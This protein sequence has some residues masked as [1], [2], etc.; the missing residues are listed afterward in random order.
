MMQRALISNICL[1]HPD[2]VIIGSIGTISYD[3]TSLNFPNKILIRGA[4]GAALGCGLGYAM[5][6]DKEVVV[7]IGD[8]ALLMHMGSIANILKYSLPN[9]K[10]YVI[11]NGSYVS[12]GGQK[13]EFFEISHLII[14]LPQF[15]VLKADEVP[16]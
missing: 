10:V 7:I 14:Q 8:G 3:L 12:C 13:N 6:T 1:K 2:A 11:Y 16:N 15:E 9:L 5:N 4:M